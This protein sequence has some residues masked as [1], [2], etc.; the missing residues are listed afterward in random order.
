MVSSL[1]NHGSLIS[2][3]GQLIT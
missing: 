1:N 2:K 3:M